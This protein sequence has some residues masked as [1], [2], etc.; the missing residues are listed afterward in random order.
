MNDWN[1][2]VRE[3][4]RIKTG[5]YML[6]VDGA[7]GQFWKRMYGISVDHCR[8]GRSM[9]TSVID[10]NRVLAKLLDVSLYLNH[11]CSAFFRTTL[12]AVQ[13]QSRSVYISARCANEP[14]TSLSIS[15][16]VACSAWLAVCRIF[17]IDDAES[18]A[19]SSMNLGHVIA[20]TGNVYSAL[21]DDRKTT[22]A[23]REVD[24]EMC[25]A[26]LR[27]LTHN[28]NGHARVPAHS[29]ILYESAHACTQRRLP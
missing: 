18:R 16:H 3:V 24:P 26:H 12:Y 13:D 29:S 14:L 22:S 8:E 4:G 2:F 1:F 25:H 27:N 21:T 23:C 17:F 10:A 28:D 20:P 19:I 15:R 11:V 5:T 7:M 9:F 6:K